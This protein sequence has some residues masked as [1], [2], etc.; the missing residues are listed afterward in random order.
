MGSLLIKGEELKRG[1]NNTCKVHMHGEN[2]TQSKVFYRISRLGEE[3]KTSVPVYQS[4][5]VNKTG[6]YHQWKLIEMPSYSLFRDN[7]TLALQVEVFHAT[8]LTKFSLIGRGITTFRGLLRKDKITLQLNEKHLDGIYIY[9]YINI[10]RS[11]NSQ[12]GFRNRA[13]LFS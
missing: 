12:Y 8:S 4:E 13:P 1:S 6:N 10:P 7:P 11:N 9:I 5:A 2:I 3:H